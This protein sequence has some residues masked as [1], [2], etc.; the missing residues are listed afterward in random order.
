[1]DA[2]MDAVNRRD[3]RG[4]ENSQGGSRARS[5]GV[6]RVSAAPMLVPLA[7]LR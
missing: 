2:A 3:V 5:S 7:L 6:L 1:M 4:S